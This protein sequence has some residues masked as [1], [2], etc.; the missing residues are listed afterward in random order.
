MFNGAVRSQLGV[1]PR[2]RFSHRK[3]KS[4]AGI[5]LTAYLRAATDTEGALAAVAICSHT[6][7]VTIPDSRVPA[8]DE[9]QRGSIFEEFRAG[10]LQTRITYDRARNKVRRVGAQEH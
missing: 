4:T 6:T 7:M 8:R 3:P 9:L 5:D 1:A 2:L 10:F